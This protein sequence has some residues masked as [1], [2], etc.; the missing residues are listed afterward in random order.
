MVTS[1]VSQD[2]GWRVQ[3]AARGLGDI[4][5]NV[6]AADQARAHERHPRRCQ[7][8][9]VSAGPQQAC[10][11]RDG[12]SARDRTEHRLQYALCLIFLVAHVLLGLSTPAGHSAPAVVEAGNAQS[13]GADALVGRV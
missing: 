8:V 3:A 5:G 13:I 11:L 6:V 7:S 9:I 1:I 12:A 2:V 4:D 10:N